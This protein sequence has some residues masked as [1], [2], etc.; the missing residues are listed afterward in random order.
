[1]DAIRPTP[2][3]AAAISD[4]RVYFPEIDGLRFLAFFLVLFNH[5]PG[6]DDFFG[7]GPLT[8][9]FIRVQKF[10]WFGV[11]IFLVLSSLLIFSLLAVEQ[12]RRGGIS[13]LGFYI[14]RA[15]R[16]WPIYFPYLLL[17]LLVLPLIPG[18]QTDRSYA[19]GLRQHLL[20]L[21]A[22]TGNLSYAAFP[23][24]VTAYFAHLWT[25][26]LEE[27]FYLC[28]PVLAFFF[29]PGRQRRFAWILAALLAAG[30]LYRLYYHGVS[31]DLPHPVAWVTPL[32]RLD[33]LIVGALC[34]IGLHARP[35]RFAAIPGYVY[36]LAALALFALTMTASPSGKSIHIVWQLTAIAV[37]AAALVVGARTW[38]PLRTL[39]TCRP[40]VFLGKISYGLYIYHLPVIVVLARL[41][42]P[43][44][45]F[46]ATPLGWFCFAGLVLAATIALGAVSYLF[47]ERRFLKLKERFAAVPSRPI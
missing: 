13:I 37:G 36:A 29:L 14:R 23:D 35:Q 44:Q 24:S 17:A 30:M 6:V 3:P 38:P 27:Q 33:P 21:L 12:D 10:G 16:I 11:D 19:D 26:S 1:M 32:V 18:L 40:V 39:F 31:S 43:A 7:G 20:P 8:A 47:Y 46:G 34:A 9:F 42:D 15:L 22:F 25:I 28:A 45:A 4:S 2:N 41:I 5:L